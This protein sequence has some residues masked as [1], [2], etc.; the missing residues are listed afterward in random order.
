MSNNREATQVLKTLGSVISVADGI[1]TIKG[2]NNA[3]YVN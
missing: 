2:L 1:V 3:S